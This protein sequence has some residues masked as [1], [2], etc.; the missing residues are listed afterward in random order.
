M[1]I[2]LDNDGTGR[3]PRPTQAEVLRWIEKNWDGP[4][5]LAIQAPTGVGKSFIASTVQ[6]VT[7]AFVIVPSNILLDDTYAKVY[8]NT[9]FLKGKTHY[10]CDTEEYKGMTCSDVTQV[11]KK[12]LCE[13][14]TYSACRRKALGGAPTFFNPMSLFYLQKHPDYQRPDVIIVDE[15]HQL[16]DMLML[17][18]GKSFRRGKYDFP[19]TVNETEII[20]WMQ[21]QLD[22][23]HRLY[24]AAL[25]KRDKDKAT[26]FAREIE[27]VQGTLWGVQENPQNY[28]IHISTKEYR[29]RQEQYLNVTPL[30]PPRYLVKQLLDTPKLILMSATLSRMDV[31]CLLKGRPYKYLDLPSPIDKARRKVCYKP[32]PFLMNFKTDPAKIVAHL[33][34]VIA[35]NPG[36]NTMIHAS[37][38]LAEKL[39][40]HFKI[41]VIT[42]TVETKNAALETFKQKGGVFLAS[43]F[44]EGIDMKGDLC[45]LNIV[46]MIQRL[47]PFDPAVKKRLA[48]ADGRKWY[49]M[50]ALKTLIQQ[51]GR[52]TRGETDSSKIVVCD[53]AFP[54]LVMK[55]KDDVPKSFFDSISWT[56]K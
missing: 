13:G 40:P 42:H 54:G 45:R 12:K 53:P 17:I 29:G 4:E 27:S 41:P 21:K 35:E 46:P 36:L 34:Q 5:V 33:E 48:W 24:G 51:A 2:K 44:A 55:N 11:L 49:D 39:A 47:N 7:N 20:R 6:R 10:V 8:P 22:T 43:G 50:E 38:G 32:T 9:N 1:S 26:E 15:A 28:S 3:S 18:A 30:E 52:S 56:G 19:E 14:C 37:Y 31:E 23:L 16:K 25:E